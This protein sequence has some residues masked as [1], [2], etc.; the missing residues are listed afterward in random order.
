MAHVKRVS[1]EDFEVSNPTGVE[2]VYGYHVTLDENRLWDIECTVTRPNGN[3]NEL[4][5][6]FYKPSVGVGERFLTYN[7]SHPSLRGP[8]NGF[9]FDNEDIYIVG[10]WKTR[11]SGAEVWQ[12]CSTA[13]ANISGGA[14]EWIE[15]IWKNA[16][17][18]KITLKIKIHR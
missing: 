16:S 18:C 8:W 1:Q 15:M 2:T 6:A 7:D 11:F 4:N 13:G 14:G 17:D 5:L 3:Q 10:T 9:R 12:E